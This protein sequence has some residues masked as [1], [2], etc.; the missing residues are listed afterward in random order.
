MTA[1]ATIAGAPL[2]RVLLRIPYSGAWWAD[3]DFLEAPDVDGAV[4]LV[5][6]TRT[7]RGTVDRAGAFGLQR[8]VRIVGGAAGWGTLMSPQHYHSDA[9]I[10][11]RQVADDAAA[12]AGE[13]LATS[14]EPEA[15]RLGIDYVRSAG[16][17]SRVLEEAIGAA[18]WWV[19]L[20]GVTQVGT[21]AASEPA[22][23]S[24]ELLEHDPR[25]GLTTLG[26]D[27][28]AAV[29]VGS[30]I[31]SDRLTSSVTVR[32]LEIEIGGSIQV[33]AWCQ[34]AAPRRGGRLLDAFSGLVGRLTDG[35][36]FGAWR[37]RVVRMQGDRVDLQAVVRRGPVPDLV[38]I[39]MRPGVAGAHAELAPSSEVL[40]SF[41]EGKRT[42]PFISHFAGKGAGWAPTKSVLA[43]TRIEL[44][45][46]GADEEVA[47]A[48]AVNSRFDSI[49]AA[50]DAF[51]AAVPVTTP[52]GDGGTALQAAVKAVWGTGVPPTEPADVGSDRVFVP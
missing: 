4:E 50:L 33:R 38:T 25:T 6:G 22:R 20:E 15:D 36:L 12:A 16:P 51:C 42:L 47:K 3:V 37:Y 40:V 21:R 2:E 32:E 30:V 26:V 27:D 19:D 28:V 14:W 11:A 18:V 8:R 48:S 10:T 43:G 34:E 23:E 29:G 9:Q 52:A 13:Q 17:A 1:F 44:A 49:A 31:A 24:Y 46:A 7:L 45:D 39:S 5:L 41:I 35:L